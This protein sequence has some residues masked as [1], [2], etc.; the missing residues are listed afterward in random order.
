MESR[1]RTACWE[2]S[3]R[4]IRN[5]FVPSFAH[6]R[7]C[8]SHSIESIHA[9]KR[10][11]EQVVHRYTSTSLWLDGMSVCSRSRE[12]CCSSS[13]FNWSTKASN[14]CGSCS[15][16]MAAHKCFQGELVTL[17]PFYSVPSCEPIST[18]SALPRLKRQA[19]TRASTLNGRDSAVDESN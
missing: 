9:R 19:V 7:G 2:E 1:R 11:H 13:R 16:M 10:D 3:L 14:L 17:P 18:A 8:A 4:Q 6:I 15:F 12:V 5:K